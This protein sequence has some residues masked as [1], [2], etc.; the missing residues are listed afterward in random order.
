MDGWVLASIDPGGSSDPTGYVLGVV[1]KVERL[2]KLQVIQLGARNPPQTPTST[3]SLCLELMTI[4][5]ERFGL[6]PMRFVVD[7]SS[8]TAVGHL[9][10]QA[11]PRDALIGVRINAADAHGAAVSALP[12][13]DVN[14]RATALP[15]LSFS[16]RQ[17][18]LDLGTAFSQRLV[19]LPIEDESQKPALQILRDQMARASL[20][21]TPSGRE[22][23]VVNKGHDDLVMA[24]A[25][26][27]ASAMRLSGAPRPARQAQVGP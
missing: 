5:K 2:T 18:L 27:W 1:R 7:L 8:N 14:G 13:G 4:A 11:L 22:I 6:G 20:K 12:V 3:V 23:A 15:C 16:R 9:L 21:T 26:G 10:A 24:V 25:Q 17:L 19:A